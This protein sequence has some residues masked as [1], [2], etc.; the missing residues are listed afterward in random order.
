MHRKRDRERERERERDKEI[1]IKFKF[2]LNVCMYECM[3]VKLMI[4]CVFFLFFF[5]N[6]CKQLRV[7]NSES[8][9]HFTLSEIRFQ[10]T[11]ANSLQ[12]F[13][14]EMQS[15]ICKRQL[16]TYPIHNTYTPT[17]TPKLE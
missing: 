6:N 17:P 5:N 8:V 1:A 12:L 9:I 7:L 10:L 3:Y 13:L 16:L 11:I 4:K 14:K 15:A 2:P